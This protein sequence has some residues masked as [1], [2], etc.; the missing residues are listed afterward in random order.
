MR[1]VIHYFSLLLIIASSVSSRKYCGKMLT[2]E[3]SNT[4][5][6]VD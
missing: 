3:L 6:K 4:C 5:I 2:R 1:K